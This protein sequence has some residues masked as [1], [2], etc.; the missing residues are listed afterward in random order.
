MRDEREKYLLLPSLPEEPEEITATALQREYKKGFLAGQKKA[1]DEC[2]EI[3]RELSQIKSGCS[4]WLDEHDKKV[5][6]YVVAKFLQTAISRKIEVSTV[7]N[8]PIQK[9]TYLD[10]VGTG[11]LRKIAN[12]ILGVENYG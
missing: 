5:T 6:E 8:K 11:E 1:Y 3:A 2:D 7:K 9:Y 4:E 10:A 12:E